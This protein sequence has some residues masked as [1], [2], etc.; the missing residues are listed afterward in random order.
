MDFI[1]SEP[2]YYTKKEYTVFSSGSVSETR[3][4]IGF[5]GGNDIST[6]KDLMIVAAGYDVSLISKAAQYNENAEVVPLL[7]F[8][9]LSADMFQEN[10]LRTESADESF[11]LDALR[12]PMFAPAYDPFET[13]AILSSYIF[14]N[15][16]LE[17][18][19]HIYLCPLSA[20]PQVLGIG[21]AYLNSFSD[22]PVSVLYPFTSNYSKE[23]SVG[24]S[25]IW[26]YTIEFF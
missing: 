14:K 13:A 24:L 3:Q 5:Q 21:L 11:S 6:K 20:K 9:S 4:V 12:A 19:G 15:K 2:S 10:M 7:G 25:R 26:K 17:E 23:T 8:P 16:C 1:Y 22:Q 18:Y